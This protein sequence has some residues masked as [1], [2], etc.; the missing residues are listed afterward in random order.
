[1]PLQQTTFENIVTKEEIARNEHFLLFPQCFQLY[2]II[3]LL[4][5]EIFSVICLLQ[6]VVFGKGLL[7][8]RIEYPHSCNWLKQNIL[9]FFCR[10]HRKRDRSK[11]RIS[12]Y[13]FPS[14]DDNR[15]RSRQ[16]TL[17]YGAEL[18]RQ[19]N[20]CLCNISHIIH[21]L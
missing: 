11:E 3:K 18:E 5:I 19:V 17:S 14:D 8:Y 12:P 10:S 2:S 15:S 13:Q 20:I 6:I 4:I 7:Q 16:D 21:E 1:M 9:L